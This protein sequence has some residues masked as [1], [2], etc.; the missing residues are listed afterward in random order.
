MVDGVKVKELK[1]RFRKC[2]YNKKKNMQM[3]QDK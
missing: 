1:L 2:K 3:I